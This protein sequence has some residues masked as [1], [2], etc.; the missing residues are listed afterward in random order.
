MNNK[1]ARLYQLLIVT[2]GFAIITITTIFLYNS[3]KAVLGIS[4]AGT[5]ISIVLAILAIVYTYIDSSQQKENAAELKKSIKK[6]RATL[7]EEKDI[8]NQLSL[9]IGEVS[10]LKDELL[11][12]INETSE[13]RKQVI[14]EIK[15]ISKDK[16]PDE[17][18]EEVE[19]IINKKDSIYQLNFDKE[20][21]NY[22]LERDLYNLVR[23]YKKVSVNDLQS[24]MLHEM[25]ILHHK[26]AIRKSLM[27]LV[28]EGMLE[29][30]DDWV[31]LRE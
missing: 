3:E 27:H 7:H 22:K 26:R 13:W 19:N 28:V 10:K 11:L 23:K 24:M 9:E 4:V 14:D 25:A 8:V 17:F 21:R 30:K 29:I 20:S 16:R 31:I 5:L 18:Q 12:S 1:R 6:L 15:A 2:L